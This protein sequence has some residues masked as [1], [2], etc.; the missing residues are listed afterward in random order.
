[1]SDGDVSSFPIEGP[2]GY[3]EAGSAYV[4]PE[5]SW[6]YKFGQQPDEVLLFKCYDSLDDGNTARQVFH[7]AF[8]DPSQAHMPPRESSELRCLVVYDM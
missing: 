3:E 7:S 5:Q 4:R 6:V 8:A 2:Y 1:M